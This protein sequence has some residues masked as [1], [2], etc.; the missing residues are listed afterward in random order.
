MTIPTNHYS[1]DESDTKKEELMGEGEEGS[2]SVME[3]DEV[4]SE[5]EDVEKLYGLQHYDSE[6]DDGPESFAG[7]HYADED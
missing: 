4:K 2:E 1:D 6:E 5:E 3:A 7:N